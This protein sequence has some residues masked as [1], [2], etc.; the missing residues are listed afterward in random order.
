MTEVRGSEMKDHLLERKFFSHDN[1]K[2]WKSINVIRELTKSRFNSEDTVLAYTL[3]IR[4]EDDK[5]ETLAYFEFENNDTSQRKIPND[6]I[7]VL[8]ENKKHI[9]SDYGLKL[10]KN[11]LRIISRQIKTDKSFKLDIDMETTDLL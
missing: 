1:H 11:H 6:V 3:S 7:K 8:H 10:R 4:D 9:L 5:S 2:K